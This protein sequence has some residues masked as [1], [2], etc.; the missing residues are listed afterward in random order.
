ML[1]ASACGSV[2]VKLNL[3]E[4]VYHC[5]SCEVIIDRDLNAAM[6]LARLAGSAP[7]RI[8][9]RGGRVRRG[10]GDSLGH[11][12]PCETLTKQGH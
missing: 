5:D 8:N 3:S 7:G 1:N 10:L 11:A 12:A 9:E 6:N 2:K 4:R